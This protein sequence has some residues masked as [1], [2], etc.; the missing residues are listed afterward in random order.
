MAGDTPLKHFIVT[1]TINPPTEA[2]V[3]FDAMPGW[4]LIVVGDRRTPIDY[5]LDQGTYL[6]PKDQEAFDG[7][8][9]DAIGWNCIQRRNIGIAVAYEQ[10]ADVVAL[11]DD[12]NI[13]DV[14]W[15]K[16]LSIGQSIEVNYFETKAPAFD[17]IGATN[18]PALWH[19]GYPLPL[20]SERDYSHCVKRTIVPD[21]EANFWNGD[22]DIDALC[23]ME[24][25]PQCA[26]DPKH[27]PI[28][29]NAMAPFNS[30][31]TIL[32]RKVLPDYFLFPY[33]GRMDDIWA[34]YYLQAKGHVVVFGGPSVYQARNDHDLVVDMRQE[35]LGY[36]CNLSLV[37]DLAR[38]PIMITKY[39]PGASAWAWELY[40][41]HFRNG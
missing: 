34:A 28:A 16:H 18:Y 37:K 40:Q 20:L 27:F 8:L 13:P 14:N 9:S 2:I 10:G 33:I 19:R 26:F 41:R 22:P 11:V 7:P 5:S 31:N 17:P 32:L 21:V 39:L 36:E 25:K 30:Q 24:H 35:L 15:G 1:T 29:S 12:D 23:R 38:D 6:S 3:K 4:H